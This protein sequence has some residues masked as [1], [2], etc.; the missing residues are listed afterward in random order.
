[1]YKIICHPLFYL[2]HLSFQLSNISKRVTLIC[3]HTLFLFFFFT[4]LD[5]FYYMEKSQYNYVS[6]C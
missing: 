6:Y 1:M 4:A 3:S 5:Y 2:L